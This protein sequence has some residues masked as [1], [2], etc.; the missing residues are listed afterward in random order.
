MY[1]LIY[2]ILKSKRLW[3]NLFLISLSHICWGDQSCTITNLNNHPKKLNKLLFHFIF[4]PLRFTEREIE[5]GWTSEASDCAV[6]I[7]HCW[8]QF[9]S[10]RLG[11]HSHSL[12]FSQGTFS[13]LLLI[14]LLFDIKTIYMHVTFLLILLFWLF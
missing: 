6:W 3:K 9:Q 1:V 5:D 14:S 8:T 2:C 10:W 4:F 11:F 7:L 13:L 12:V